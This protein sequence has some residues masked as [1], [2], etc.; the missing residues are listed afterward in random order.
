MIVSG[1][2][3]IRIFASSA[4]NR[5]GVKKKNVLT[6]TIKSA[7]IDQKYPRIRTW[8]GYSLGSVLS[9]EIVLFR[10]VER[11]S[12]PTRGGGGRGG[13]CLIVR[14]K[15]LM[16][17]RRPVILAMRL[18]SVQHVVKQHEWALFIYSKLVRTSVA[19]SKNNST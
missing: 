8:V 6:R 1:P 5:W 18:Y 16:G 4:M 10:N 7:S 11:I 17:V 2:K 19:V 13:G 14:E 9:A 12:H 3:R 15:R